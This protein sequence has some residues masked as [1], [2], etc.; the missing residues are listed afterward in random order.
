LV[1]GRARRHH[2]DDRPR[3]FD[4]LGKGGEAL[5]W[6]DILRKRA[7]LLDKSPHARGRP[8]E[9]GDA[10][11]LFRDVERQIGTHCSEAD[12]ANVSFFH[13]TTTY[14]PWDVP[15]ARQPL[16]STSGSFPGPP[17]LPAVKL[18]PVMNDIVAQ[19]PG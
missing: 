1:H 18:K 15:G 6:H 2:Q 14:F 3:P 9:D 4:G 7:C 11:A 17:P 19:R 8:V 16:L 5:A 13:G 12:Q 10:K